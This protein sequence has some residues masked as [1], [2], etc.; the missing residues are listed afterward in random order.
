M[1]PL[2]LWINFIE[3]VSIVDEGG[4]VATI[5][6]QQDD[7][8]SF[9]V[10]LDDKRPI[11]ESALLAGRNFLQREGAD[12]TPPDRECFHLRTHQRIEM[13]IHFLDC[14]SWRLKFMEV[15]RNDD[16]KG[17]HADSF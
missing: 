17:Q 13:N 15:I 6:R 8:R 11:V 16:L 7:H 5:M 10:Q 9:R 3:S 2:T 4:D 14:S 1:S 12:M